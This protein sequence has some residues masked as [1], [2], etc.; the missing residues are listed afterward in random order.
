MLNFLIFEISIASFSLLTITITSM[1]VLIAIHQYVFKYWERRGIHGPSNHPLIGSFFS[2]QRPQALFLLDN[3]RKYG[4]IYGIFQG[5]KPVLM[6]GDP[7]LIKKILVSD[8]NLFRNRFSSFNQERVFRKN[9]SFVR[10]NDWKRI[11]SILTPMFTTSKMK[12]MGR[13]LQICIDSLLDAIEREIDTKKHHTIEI[14]E[15]INNFTMDAIAQ[16]C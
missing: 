3:Y 13:S 1:T 14:Q 8:F 2:F 5:M 16:T 11:R 12:K 15:F 6:I 10:D 7:I 4:K 9:L